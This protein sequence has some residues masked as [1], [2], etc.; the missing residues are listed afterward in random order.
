MTVFDNV[1][2]PNENLFI[3]GEVDF[4]GKLA[5]RFALYHRHS[6][7]G[8]KPGIGDVLLGTT[9]LLA[10]YQ[11][12]KNQGHVKEKIAELISVAELVFAAGIAAASATAAT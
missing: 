8:C 1:F 4:A 11:G 7:T 6:Y 3:N 12:I 10:D 2:I 9:A 5:L